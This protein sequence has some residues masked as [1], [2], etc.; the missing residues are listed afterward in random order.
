[1]GSLTTSTTQEAQQIGCSA[2]FVTL[3]GPIRETGKGEKPTESMAM[4]LVITKGSWGPPRELVESW[5][6]APL[7][8]E[9][10]GSLS[11]I[12]CPSRVGGD[13][14]GV[15]LVSCPPCGAT[16]SHRSVQALWPGALHGRPGEPQ[17]PS[18]PTTSSWYKHSRLFTTSNSLLEGGRVCII[19][20]TRDSCI[21]VGHLLLLSVGTA[22]HWGAL[23]R[24]CWLGFSLIKR[25]QREKCSP[26]QTPGAADSLPEADYPDPRLSPT[27][28]CLPGYLS[29]LISVWLQMSC[30][31]DQNH[32]RPPFFP[33]WFWPGWRTKL[34]P[35]TDAIISFHCFLNAVKYTE[36]KLCHFS[37]F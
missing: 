15:S 36:H 35:V 10:L 2:L 29:G 34:K 6:A 22:H 25:A 16:G 24:P 7:R 20:Q 30:G 21:R 8:A 4:G 9:E 14:W 18:S 19:F 17:P 27:P 31:W 5:P 23:A 3:G 1:M 33:P 32:R 13:S 11:P 12:S 37:H 26:T 28:S